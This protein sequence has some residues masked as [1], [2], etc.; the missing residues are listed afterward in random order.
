M[1]RVQNISQNG[2]TE[3]GKIHESVNE[4]FDY[5]S[6]YIV[7]LNIMVFTRLVVKYNDSLI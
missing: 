3:N 2:T 4:K 6:N 5:F 7:R 1:K